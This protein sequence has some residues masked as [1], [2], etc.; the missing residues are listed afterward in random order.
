[1]FMKGLYTAVIT[2]FDSHGNLDEA[3]LKLN[4]THQLN[5]HVDGILLMGSTG[6]SS[7]ITESE[8][9]RIIEI[10]VCELK[11]RAKIMVGTGCNS[12]HKTILQTKE[13][14][15]LGADIALVVTPYYNKP[16]QE[17]I[18]RH[19]KAI[20]DSGNLP[21]CIYNNP[22]RSIQNIQTDTLIRIS[23]S[24]QFIGVKEA[25]GNLSQMCDVLDFAQK[26]KNYS[27]MSGDDFF[28]LPL[29]FMGGQGLI[30]TLSNLIP[31]QMK[32]LVDACLASRLSEAQDI[33][34]QLLPLFK[35]LFIE[36]N[37]MPIKTAME[38]FKMPA[39]QCRLPLCQ[40]SSGNY[41]ELKR[42]LSSIPHTW[43]SAH[44]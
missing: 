25:S 11:G 27:V 3:G 15:E 33:H 16:T 14:E 29:C 39:G 43:I 44:G 24:P 4:L 38:H 17:G 13:A 42:V 26:R 32:K 36:T 30:S 19:F 7:T 18:Y 40:L 41:E 10:G 34:F 1:M 6:E 5:H 2:P 22:H 12:T 23:Q 37:P 31:G 35:T 20:A 9:R 8:R 21:I 28:T